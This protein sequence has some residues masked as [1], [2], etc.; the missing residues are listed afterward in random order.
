MPFQKGV[1]GNPKGRKPGSFSLV[2]L[3]KD[4]LKE[5]P[6]GEKESVALQAISAYVKHLKDGKTEILKDA[7]DRIDGKPT[8]NHEHAGEGGGPIEITITVS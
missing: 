5:I 2:Q 1:S 3:L 8:Q 7:F 6:E 4:K